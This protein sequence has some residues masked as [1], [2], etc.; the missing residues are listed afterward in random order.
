MDGLMTVRTEQSTAD[1]RASCTLGK[2]CTENV[3]HITIANNTNTVIVQRY[4]CTRQHR[5]RA[6]GSGVLSYVQRV[7][8][9]AWGSRCTVFDDETQ[10]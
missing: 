6:P 9:E 2:T 5:A 7:I 4:V 8:A 10:F 3:E 1:L